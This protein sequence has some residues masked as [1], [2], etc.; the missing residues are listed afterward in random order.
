MDWEDKAMKYA[1]EANRILNGSV[2]I[3]DAFWSPRLR[4]FF[5]VTLP[6]TFDKFEKDGTLD[7]FRDVV[8]G[9]RNTHRACPWHD[10]LLFETIADC[11][12]NGPA[13]P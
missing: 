10:G 7:N 11:H 5:D 2:N 4:T 6:D 12:R 3:N 8:A 9:K 13:G 1:L